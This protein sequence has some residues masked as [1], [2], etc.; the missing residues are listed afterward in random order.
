LPHI[1]ARV[2]DGVLQLR[3]EALFTATWQ[4][5]LK[6]A[7]LDGGGWWTS[8]DRAD[9]EEGQWLKPLGRLDDCVKVKGVLVDLFAL[10]RHLQMTVLALPS[11]RR[12][13]DLVAVVEGPGVS[14]APDPATTVRQWNAAA[15]SHEKIRAIYLV[16]R[17]PR[18]ALGKI[19]RA[20]L[21]EILAAAAGP[22]P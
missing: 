13:H 17:L 22:P 2:K 14:G 20:E 7:E 21:K 9:L 1:E 12:E 10:E 15:A 16:P 8:C 5:K 11:H 19:K 3:T 18:T 4:G 6:P